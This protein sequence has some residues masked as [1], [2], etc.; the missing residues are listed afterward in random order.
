MTDD[1]GEKRL[2]EYNQA[3]ILTAAR[4]GSSC[5]SSNID[6]EKGDQLFD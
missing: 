1:N 2:L 3:A 6:D 5:S 4:A